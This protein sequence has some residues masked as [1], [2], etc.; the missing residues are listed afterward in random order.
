MK[1]HKNIDIDIRD[2]SGL[3]ALS[4]AVERD[5]IEM[6]Q[7]L[8]SRGAEVREAHLI[9]IMRGSRE[10]AEFLLNAINRKYGHE[11]ELE[12]IEDSS[13]FAPYITPMI[14]AAQL[15]NIEII[16]MLLARKH[17]QLSSLHIPY[18]RCQL[19]RERILTRK[20]YTEYRRNVYQAIANPN[21]ICTTA[22]D[23]FLTAFRL[24]KRLALEASIDRD[25]ASEY[26][27]LASKL[28]EFSAN[29]VSMC[30]DN[31]EVEIVLKE[32]TGYKDYPGAKV[33]FPRLQLALEFEEKLFIATPQ[34]QSTLRDKWLRHRIDWSWKSPIDK[35]RICLLH[36]LFVPLVAI[37]NIFHPAL[38]F[39]QRYTTPHSTFIL[40][41][42]SSLIFNALLLTLMLLDM[43]RKTT[44]P[45]ETGLEFV[46][47]LFVAA[48]V[49]LILCPYAIIM[50]WLYHNYAGLKS[51]SPNGETTTQPDG[52][53]TLPNSIFTLFWAVLAQSEPDAANVVTA[54]T[55]A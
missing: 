46:I 12:G 4:S 30:R 42:T 54:N 26:H 9:A 44:G 31:D 8:L 27:S 6:L 28:R 19:C 51:Q 50:T 36:I 38:D 5:D 43:K 32:P 53:T 10:K 39:V 18:C 1:T 52:F 16:Q 47:V 34:V 7:F 45:P 29:L 15:G 13:A 3:T 25:Y 41:F 49:F 33:L 11:K 40:H 48:G 24:R 23:P 17:P 21:Y 20:S 37:I 2:R 35:I 14:L 22:E 55:A